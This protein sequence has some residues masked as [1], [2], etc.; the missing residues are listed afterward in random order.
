MRTIAQ[1]VANLDGWLESVR[2]P[3]GYGGPVVHWWQNTLAYTGAGLDWRYEGIIAGYLTLWQRTGQ[4]RWLE[5]ACR[6]GDDL[7][8]GQL[9]SGHFRHSRF[10][11][12]PH[13]GGTPHEAAAALALF[14]LA[15]ALRTVRDDRWQVYAA[16][17][18]R[19]VLGYAIT[20]LWNESAQHFRDVP[21]Q[22]FFVPNKACT[23]VEALFA[24][25]TLTGSDEPIRRYGLPT[26]R[27][28][29][30]LQTRARGR[31][32]GAIAQARIHGRTVE[33][34]FPYYVA[35]CVPAL[36]LAHEYTGAQR[37]LDA[38]VAA[39]DFV[40]RHRDERGLLTQV[41][42]RRGV[43][44]YPQWVAPLGDVLRVADLLRPY[45]A[46]A[47]WSQ[48]RT[49]LRQGQ[50]ASGGIVTGRGFG[51][52]VR[53]RIPRQQRKSG[54]QRDFRDMIPVAG[55]C[56]KAFRYLATQVGAG[57]TLPPAQNDPVSEPC[58]LRGQRALWEE[59]AHTMRLTIDQTPVY[60][61]RK[62]ED[63]A[64]TL[65]PQMMWK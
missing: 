62:G 58:L 31:L 23:L 21:G 25:S 2:G 50:A 60:C 26:L 34:Y 61:W 32:A 51:A 29:L 44:R 1:A 12:N 18:E 41:L 17:A 5:R 53:Q 8:K 6:A 3:D 24:W 36:L 42:Y 49:A 54:P 13:A 64:A 11:M 9:A 43:N 30:A 57:A 10:E 39:M 14:Q 7:R 27:S 40:H 19:N 28:V 33:S 56:D 48:T 55:W 46:G 45:G 65:S 47:D 59:D 37:W 4:A 20:R 63:W 35:R 52:Q 22:P 38:A 15:R 16:A